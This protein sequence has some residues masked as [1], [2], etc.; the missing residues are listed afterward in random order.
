[1]RLGIALCLS[2]IVLPQFGRAQTPV[3]VADIA[4]VHSLVARV[5]KGVGEPSVLLDGQTT[6]HGHAMRPSQARAIEG[7][8]IVVIASH[9][10]TPWVE[11]AVDSLASGTRLVVLSE[12]DGATLHPFRAG[13]VFEA[14][15]D[16]HGH[17]HGH[18]HEESEDGIDPHVWLDPENAK[19]WVQ[20]LADDLGRADPT[21]AETYASNADAAV[22]E[23]DVA[24]SD[25]LALLGPLAGKAF[26]ALHDAYQYLEYRFDLAAAGAVAA[27]DAAPAGPARLRE[28]GDHLAHEDV[29]CV[30]SEGVLNS[31]VIATVLPGRDIDVVVIDPLGSWLEPGP[32]FYPEFI[33]DIARKFA[34]CLSQT[35]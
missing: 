33:V 18:D 29:H 10:L 5:M 6:P 13:S 9:G 22:A 34:A 7:A 21:N 4:P 15:D 27:S 35:G 14:H 20:A 19:V 30:V 2:L 16:D 32:G 24:A 31:D 12:V 25:A 17:D 23:I 11:N 8:D 26:V 28:L 1:M 3:V